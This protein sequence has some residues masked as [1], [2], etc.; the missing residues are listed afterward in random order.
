MILLANLQQKKIN[1]MFIQPFNSFFKLQ[2]KIHKILNVTLFH[3]SMD[4]DH[5]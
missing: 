4:E 3:K 1:L 5:N 2:M